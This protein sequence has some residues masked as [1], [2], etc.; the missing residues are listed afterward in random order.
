MSN[1]PSPFL[2]WK[3]IFRK[4]YIGDKP[5]SFTFNL[6]LSS[7]CWPTYTFFSS[8][9]II[10]LKIFSN[11]GGIYRSCLTEKSTKIMEN[12]VN[13][14]NPEILIWGS[15]LFVYNFVEEI[16]VYFEIG[17]WSTCWAY[18]ESICFFCFVIF[19]AVLTCTFIHWLFSFFDLPRC[20]SK[21][22][23]RYCCNYDWY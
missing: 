3:S 2:L 4:G 11:L 6:V 14:V 19:K 20:S 12:Y 15:S 8:P 17:D 18:T 1:F 13:E 16:G 7:I 9:N 5:F 22:R 23:K 10:N 21:S